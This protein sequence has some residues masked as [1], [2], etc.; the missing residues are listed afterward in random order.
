MTD[1]IVAIR[2]ARATDAAVIADIYNHYVRDTIITFEEEAVTADE[3]ARRIEEIG[4]AGLPWLVAEKEEAVAGFAYASKW[5][6]RCAYRFS[7]EVTVYIDAARRGEGLGRAL[8]SSLLRELEARGIHTA[9]A[10]IALPNDASV[11]IHES[12]GFRKVAQLE[13]V[14][15]KFGRW[16]DV[17]YWQRILGPPKPG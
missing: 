7:A 16:I 13:Q 10:G 2:P 9:L 12:F 4:T 14:G 11:R 1:S 5:K 15:F 3:M 8:Y 6:G 17:G